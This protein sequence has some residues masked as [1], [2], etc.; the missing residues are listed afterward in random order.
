MTYISQSSDLSSFIFCSEKHFSFIGKAW[1]RQLMLSWQL[2]LVITLNSFLLSVKHYINQSTCHLSCNIKLTIVVH[3]RMNLV[4]PKRFILCKFWRMYSWASSWDHGTFCPPL[5]HSSNTLA[6]PSSATRCL[7]FGPTYHLL[8]YFMFVK[9]EGSGETA[10]MNRLTWA[11]A[12]A[13]LIS[14]IISWAGSFAF[15]AEFSWD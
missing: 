10:R 6:Q 11:L 1:F 13:Y 12:V 14:A 2:L 5:T 7:N 8:P 4:C 3:Q 15:R 9:S